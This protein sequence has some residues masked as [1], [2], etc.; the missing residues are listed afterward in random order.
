VISCEWTPSSGITKIDALLVAGGGG[1]GS[2]HGGGGG[3]GG[4]LWAQNF[5]VS[6]SQ[7]S[8]SIGSGGAGATG[9]S[10]G[11][12]GSN[13]TNTNLKLTSN[14]ANGLTA[15]GGGGGGSGNGLAGGSGGGSSYEL[16][17]VGTAN[18]SSQTQKSLTGTTLVVG[19][20]ADG[21]TLTNYGYNGG[22]GIS[23]VHPNYC[24]QDWCGGGG[25]GAGA[26]GGNATI[27][28]FGVTSSNGLPGNGGV[29]IVNPISGSTAGQLVSSSYYLA[30]GGGGASS[31]SGLRGSG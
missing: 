8:I 7:L 10:S 4:V 14:S 13:G 12:T 28:G 18:Q 9:G 31:D 25:G 11:G 16:S 30:G 17:A 23:E 1:G 26:V 27:S 5:V 2:R 21:T 20:N 6:N 22:K 3:A 24:Q 15:S 29:G 19:S